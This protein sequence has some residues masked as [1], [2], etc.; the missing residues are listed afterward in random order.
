MPN[1]RE[2]NTRNLLCSPESANYAPA[3]PGDVIVRLPGIVDRTEG[4]LPNFLITL[5]FLSLIIKTLIFLITVILLSLIFQMYILFI[6]LILLL[7][8][9]NICFSFISVGEPMRNSFMNLTYVRRERIESARASV[10]YFPLSS[11]F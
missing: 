6:I 2:P 4:E 8:I 5:I 7:L 1:I 9:I 11:R 10:N 3:E